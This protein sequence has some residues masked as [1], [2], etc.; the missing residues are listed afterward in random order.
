[1]GKRFADRI[2]ELERLE[3]ALAPYDGRPVTEWSDV[4]LAA[5]LEQA[6]REWPRLRTMSDAELEAL[7]AEEL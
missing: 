3:R 7:C 4:E 1:M 5:Y 2:A 6:Y